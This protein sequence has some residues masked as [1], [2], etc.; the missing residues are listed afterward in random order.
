[1]I[2]CDVVGMNWIELPAGKY[3][4]RGPAAKVSRQQI[5]VDVSYDEFISHP[6]EGDWSRIAPLR[7]LSFDIECAGRKCVRR[8]PGCPQ[9]PLPPPPARLLRAFARLLPC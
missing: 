5:E 3:R 4:L 7:V 6:A 8:G 9:N 1:M 2:D